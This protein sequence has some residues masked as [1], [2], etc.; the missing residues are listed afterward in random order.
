[1]HRQVTLNSMAPTI[2]GI[3]SSADENTPTPNNEI[4]PNIDLFQ[5]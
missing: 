5:T 3:S 2:D 1:M 4:S